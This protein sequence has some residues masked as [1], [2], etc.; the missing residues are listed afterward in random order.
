[1]SSA[2]GMGGAA[3]ARW[4]ALISGSPNRRILGAIVVI[5]GTTVGVKIAS[6]AKDLL[7]ASVFGA[8]GQLD[9]FFIALVLP[10]FFVSIVTSAVASAFI[11][12]YVK[13]M[14]QDGEAAAQRLFSGVLAVSIALLTVATAALALVGPPLLPFLSSGFSAGN[15]ELLR[16]L[17][18]LMLL[19]VPLTGLT[20]IL[21][22]VLN[23]H[24]A[25]GVA[26]ATEIAIPIGTGAGLLF[27]TGTGGVYAMTVGMLL[28]ICVQ[29][30]VLARLAARRGVRLRP[31]W[32]G[33]DP[34]IMQVVGQYLPAAAGVLLILTAPII[35][36]AM[37][38]TLGEGSVA[39]LNYGSKIISPLMSVGVAAIGTAVLPYFSKM[40][41][42]DDWVGVRHTLRTFT[43]LILAVS[44][45]ATIAL[46]LLSEPMIRLMFQRGAFTS[47]DTHT[48]SLVNAYNL[49]QI[50]L[51]AV[52]ILFV[53]LISSMRANRIL[54]FGA[55][56]SAAINLV[57]DWWLKS[58]MGIEGIALATSVVYLSSALFLGFMLLRLLREQ[59]RRAASA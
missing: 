40:V 9:A 51:Y 1:M 31:R 41:G 30:A 14:Q 57:L 13:A 29:A 6:L 27:G 45:P 5:G 21:I 10:Y 32:L 22:S 2:A 19:M 11:P 48:V 15:E 49:I 53:R 56:I 42:A 37:A 58:L 17:F 36:Q 44:I 52:T 33:R 18:Y 46:V 25:F 8:G 26:A 59:D 4:Q 54:M 50:P 35:D 28:G 7:T 3:K 23:S 24:E 20:T 47:A 38:A 39:T 12:A 43:A 34:E 55:A 16:R